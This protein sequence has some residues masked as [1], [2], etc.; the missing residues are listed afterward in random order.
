MKLKIPISSSQY[1]GL[2]KPSAEFNDWQ[3]RSSDVELSLRHFEISA[4]DFP[5]FWQE[6][7]GRKRSLQRELKPLFLEALREIDIEEFGVTLTQV[8]KTLDQFE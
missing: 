4:E 6:F 5:V 7:L 1:V 8:M 2:E 3:Y